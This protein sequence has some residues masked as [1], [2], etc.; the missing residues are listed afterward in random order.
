LNALNRSKKTFDWENE[1]L[2]PV[3]KTVNLEL[4]HPELPMQLSGTDLEEE[5]TDIKGNL[6]EVFEETSKEQAFVTSIRTVL[7]DET[8]AEKAE[9]SSTIYLVMLDNIETPH[10]CKHTKCELNMVIQDANMDKEVANHDR[11]INNLKYNIPTL[12]PRS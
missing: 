4:A 12:E 7:E 11:N 6:V 9:M 3:E 5:V 8:D 10:E 1:D 2:V